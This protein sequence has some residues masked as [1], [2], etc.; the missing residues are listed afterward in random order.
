MVCNS[1]FAITV[2]GKLGSISRAV[3]HIDDTR[4]I[5][6]ESGMYVGHL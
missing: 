3:G 2:V 6:D 4:G 5:P 1:S